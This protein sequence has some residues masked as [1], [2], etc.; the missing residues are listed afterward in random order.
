[1]PLSDPGLWARIEAH[2]MPAD[3]TGLSFVDQ[4]RAKYDLKPETAKRA[5]LDYKRFLYLSALDRGRC[6]PS[7]AVDEVWHLHLQHTRDYWERLVPNALAGKPVHHNPGGAG[8]AHAADF[9][10][11]IARYEREF[12]EAP[13]R[14]FW[15]RRTRSRAR[16]E[17]FFTSGLLGIG[18]VA[19]WTMG[20]PVFVLMV[21]GVLMVWQLVKTVQTGDGIQVGIDVWADGSGGDCG[22]SCGGCGD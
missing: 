16:T 18:L 14:G 22:S 21:I 2:Q 9:D 11:T 7:R 1:M 5:V 6:V 8:D 4:L 12:G 13:P 15:R 19:F 17:G 20:A 3:S 10:E